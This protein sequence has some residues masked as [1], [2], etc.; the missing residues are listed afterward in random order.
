MILKDQRALVG[1]R[2]LVALKALTALM[3]LRALTAEKAELNLMVAV[4]TGVGSAV[5]WTVV[6][7]R[8]Q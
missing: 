3:A 7:T 5:V 4:T 8:R 1:L 6:E 2:A